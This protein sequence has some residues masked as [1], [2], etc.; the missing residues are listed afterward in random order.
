MDTLKWLVPLL[1][2]WPAIKLVQIVSGVRMLRGIRFGTEVIDPLSDAELPGWFEEASRP[3]AGQL[4]AAGF[5]RRLLLRSRGQLGP[6]FDQFALVYALPGEPVIAHLRMHQAVARGGECYL[7]FSS[8][9]GDGREIV[10]ASFAETSIVPLPGN[11]ALEVHPSLALTDLLARHRLRLAEASAGST[12]RPLDAEAILARDRDLLAKAHEALLASGLTEPSPEGGCLLRWGSAISAARRLLRATPAEAKAAKAVGTAPTAHLSD[13]NRTEIEYRQ[14]RQMLALQ[15]VR[16]AWVPKTL[17]MVGSLV[18]FALALRWTL[19]PGMVLVLIVALAFH[20]G[21][22]LLGMRLFGYKDTQ[23]LFLPFLGGVAVA[24]DRL[25]LAPWKHLVILF[26][27]PLPGIFV[28][29]GL[30]LWAS[31]ADSEFGLQAGFLVLVFNVF[32]LLPLLPLDGGQIMDVALVS[33]FPRLRVVF[34]VLSGLGMIAVGYGSESSLLKVVGLFTLFRIPVE[35]RQAGIVKRLRREL[36]SDADE[37]IIAKRL[38][39]ELRRPVG[40]GVLPVVQRLQQVRGLEER[41]RRPRPGWGAIGLAVGGYIAVVVVGLGLA[42]AVN[43]FRGQREIEAA[44]AR[45][46]A[47]GL[48]EIVPPAY[49]PLPD[50]DNAAIPLLELD[51][52]WTEGWRLR[53]VKPELAETVRRQFTDAAARQ[54]FALPAGVPADAD[55]TA[56]GLGFVFTALVE[57]AES[58][59]RYDRASEALDLALAGLGSLRHL[60]AAP[61]WWTDDSDQ[62]AAKA[63]WAVVEDALARNTPV[64]AEQLQRLAAAADERAL[65]EY[66]R[67]AKRHG[68]VRQ[69]R[70]Y[71]STDS[72]EE[73]PPGFNRLLWLFLRLDPDYHRSEAGHYDDTIA[74]DAALSEALA[75]RWPVSAAETDSTAAD[76][77]WDQVAWEMEQLAD[78]VAHLRVVRAG[79]AARWMAFHGEPLPEKL[80][81]LRAPWLNSPLDHP[82]TKVAMRNEPRDGVTVLALS[83]SEASTVLNGHDQ[84]LVWR[85]PARP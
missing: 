74:L 78:A 31:G 52:T 51:K 77:P 59:A 38:L 60:R 42:L 15:N 79:L 19:S 57:E 13:E 47:A 21:G 10:T 65:L 40:A 48:V 72:G 43:T 23:L 58:L 37:A 46:A 71:G 85:L 12:A 16:L 81:D 27:G 49:A 63:L 3:L 56:Q 64:S 20:E 11:I 80:S 18:L 29:I 7:T 39:A 26:L 54:G 45:A 62:A 76:K 61:H 83:R 8:P 22:H 35:W 68:K 17:L 1:L 9:L 14:F 67:L 55:T 33:R 2:I 66:A 36:P 4:V 41:V 32:N 25:V 82:W 44:R 50:A 34:L 70:W 24:R 69:M 73:V 53:P 84:D 30:L 5:E 6:E 28:G 75:G